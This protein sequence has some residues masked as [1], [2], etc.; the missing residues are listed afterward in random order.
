MLWARSLKPLKHPGLYSYS[1]QGPRKHLVYY[2]TMWWRRIFACTYCMDGLHNFTVLR[3]QELTCITSRTGVSDIAD[4]GILVRLV[5]AGGAIE[6]WAAQ[7]LI[8]V[9]NSKANHFRTRPWAGW[10]RFNMGWYGEDQEVLVQYCLNFQFL[11]Q[12]ISIIEI[13]FDL[14]LKLLK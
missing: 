1:H 5:Q 12:I 13:M 4:T 6:T 10:A 8:Y 7:T 14:I 2:S 3:L 9:W 11:P